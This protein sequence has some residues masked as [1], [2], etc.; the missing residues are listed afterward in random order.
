M[1]DTE[2][3]VRE[4]LRF[5][6]SGEHQDRNALLHNFVEQGGITTLLNL[7]TDE[8]VLEREAYYRGLEKDADS[9]RAEMEMTAKEE[10]I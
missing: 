7:L 1:W 6:D 9:F 4:N 3:R 2:E 5:L 10:V 8:S